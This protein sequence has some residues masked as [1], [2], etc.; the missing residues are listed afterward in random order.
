MLRLLS[1][2]LKYA[3]F[4]FE[5][6]ENLMLLVKYPQLRQQQIEHQDLLRTAGEL[7]AAFEAGDKSMESLLQFFV[8]WFLTHT[9]KAD[10]LAGQFSTRAARDRS[11]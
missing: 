6:E 3:D 5:S 2:L 1:E 7:T 4:H 10:R 9:Q 8:E 11:S